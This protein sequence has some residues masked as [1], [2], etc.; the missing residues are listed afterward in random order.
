M[1]DAAHI[2]C[3]AGAAGLS[4]FTVA[5]TL[6][7]C[8][9][10]EATAG[11]LRTLES[12][13][14]SNAAVEVEAALRAFDSL[15]LHARNALWASTILM[16]VACTFRVASQCSLSV[17]ALVASAMLLG[18]AAAV[19]HMVFA[20]RVVYRPLLRRIAGVAH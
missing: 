2:L 12:N 13:V 3:L 4:T 7:E 20:F 10:A 9:Y 5:F 15:R 19:L 17:T 1:L 6:L 18:S 14:F 11:A 8:Y 16:L